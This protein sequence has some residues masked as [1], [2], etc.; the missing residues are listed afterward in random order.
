MPAAASYPDMGTRMDVAAVR[1]V[2][3]QFDASTA[4]LDTAVR[5]HISALGFAGAA[6]GRAY[7][8][9]GDAL[10]AALEQVAGGL[11]Q[12]SRASAEIAASLRGSA[13]RYADA[14]DRAGARVG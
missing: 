4:V 1:E 5:S 14:D 12:W 2:A 7:V 9:R 11:T 6:A 13:D 3:D 8:A 10:R